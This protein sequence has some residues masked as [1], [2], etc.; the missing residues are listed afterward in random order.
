M[1]R[2]RFQAC[3]YEYTSKMYRMYTDMSLSDDLNAKFSEYLSQPPRSNDLEINFFASVL[4]AGSWPMPNA[5]VSS[6][7]APPQLAKCMRTF[8]IFYR[9]RARIQWGVTFSFESPE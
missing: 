2:Y 6:F 7:I 4:Q 5:A 8:E 3:G 1:I 9:V